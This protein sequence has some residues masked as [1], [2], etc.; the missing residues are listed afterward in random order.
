MKKNIYTQKNNNDYEIKKNYKFHKTPNFKYKQIITNKNFSG[1]A[2]DIFE[3]YLSYKDN[4]EYIASPN[5]RNSNVDIFILVKNQKLVSL[6]G[7]KIDIRTIRYFINNKNY[8][9]YLISADCSKTVIVWDITNNYNIKYIINNKYKDHISSCLLMFPLNINENYIITSSNCISDNIDI[10]ATKIYSL[11]NGDYIKSINNSNNY[12]ICYL[13][14]WYNKKNNNYYVIELAYKKIVINNIL[15][16][17]L[18]CKLIKEPESFHNSGFIFNKKNNDYLCCSSTNGYIN[19]WDL[20]NK[21]IYKIINTNHCFLMHI[22][23]WNN[24]YI[25]V[26]DLDNNSF[27]VFDIGIGELILNIKQ[28][29]NVVSIKKI[30]HP[31]YGESL[32]SAARDN[33]IRLWHI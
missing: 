7:H 29:S 2:N 30:Y 17:E 8:N 11:N 19:I 25:I 3:V 27:K 21:N 10:S 18:Y 1:G 4:K 14:P 16:N 24:K 12:Y 6:K 22:I 13:L 28:K 32:L 23:N 5:T 9:E 20:Y 31:I 26:A 33:T 15:E